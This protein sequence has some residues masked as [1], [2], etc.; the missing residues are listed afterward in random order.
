[1]NRRE[2]LELAG[3]G[4]LSA[5]VPPHPQDPLVDPIGLQLYTVRTLMETSVPL[6]LEM[7]AKIGYREVEFAGYFGARPEQLRRWLDDLGL[8][9]PAAHVPVLDGNLNQL[10]E[11]AAVL[12]HRYLVQASLPPQQRVSADSYRRVAAALN[13]AGEQARR[14]DLR[15]AYHN[16]DFEFSRRDDAVPYDI[17][18][19]ET[20]PE[21]VTMELDLYWM[22]KA[23]RDP[24]A[25]FH[26]HAGR[27]RLCHLKDMDQRGRMTEVG[28]GRVDFPA[29]LSQ[30]EK[31]GLRH[32]FVEHDHPPDPIASVRASYSY[33]QAQRSRE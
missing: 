21:L 4:T 31:A 29:I 12:G 15:V 32:F 2:F 14:R 5:I 18:L 19:Q 13:R 1:M 23:K 16:H 11:A 33:L 30:R 25:Y 10:F 3:L 27:F 9:S 26:H 20:D 6:T 22:T 8:S 17:L 24:L 28:R 7:V